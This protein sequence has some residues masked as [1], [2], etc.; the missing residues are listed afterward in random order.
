[1][2]A[3]ES[4][5]KK[6]RIRTWLNGRKIS[7]WVVEFQPT[8]R[9][10]I[11]CRFCWRNYYSRPRIEL[12]HKKWLEITHDACEMGV[13]RITIAGG[14][15]PLVRLKT[16]LA[17]ME[18]TKMYDVE[19]CLE[20]N[21]TLFTKNS[22]KRMVEIGWDSIGF[23]VNG[24]N[25]ETDD[26]IR[27]RKGVFNRTMNWIKEINHWKEKLG[28]SKPLL[29]FH[30]VLTK[31]SYDQVDEFV[32]LAHELKL[33]MVLFKMVNEDYSDPKNFISKKHV[34]AL[35]SSVQKTKEL[36]KS[37][38]I[39]TKFEFSMDDIMKHVG[40]GGDDK[41]LNGGGKKIDVPCP[42][43]FS[44]LVILSDGT[45]NPCCIICEGKFK[46]NAAETGVFKALEN[47]SNKSLNEVWYSKTF[48]RMREIMKKGQ[49]PKYCSSYCTLDML[50]RRE[51]GIITQDRW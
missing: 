39:E 9:C 41:E 49:L 6:K 12:P 15:E 46:P 43:P 37:W 30:T 29:K 22:V 40:L 35:N 3:N 38:N 2:T 24:A 5:S 21:G 45:T 47:I 36:A 17:I 32:K 14:G 13:K 19:G 42:K 18:E 28:S 33:E 4:D 51:T 44:E 11:K 50:Y 34:S 16:S 10:N 1:M 27:G 23:S 48:G 31:Y 8:D 26:F 7:P 20:T 25:P